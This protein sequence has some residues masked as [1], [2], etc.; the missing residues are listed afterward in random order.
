PTLSDLLQMALRYEGW[1][2]Q[3]AATGSEAAGAVPHCEGRGAGPH[4]RAD[5]LSNA[6]LHTPPG[7]VVELALPTTASAQGRD[8]VITVTD[9]APGVPEELRAR[10]FERSACLG[11][12][13]RRHRATQTAIG[14][15]RS[16]AAAL[17]R[18][19][20]I[21]CRDA[22]RESVCRAAAAHRVQSQRA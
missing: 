9:Q 21:P 3:T 11:R 8:A 2:V 22:F 16:V 10:V 13:R 15:R 19:E 20:D 4:R 5:L 12:S 6:R 7:T 1:Q 17:T 18:G 14:P